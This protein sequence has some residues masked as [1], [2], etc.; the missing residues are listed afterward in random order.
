MG[1]VGRRRLPSWHGAQ[2]DGVALGR[3]VRLGSDGTPVFLTHGG[4]NGYWFA[5][6][7]VYPKQDT[8]ILMVTNFGNATAEKSISTLAT[9]SLNT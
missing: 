2:L 6:I 4:S 8:V 5:T 9:D 1:C 7:R 3:G